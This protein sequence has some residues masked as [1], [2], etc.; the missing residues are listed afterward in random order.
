[1][2]IHTKRPVKIRNKINAYELSKIYIPNKI[3]RNTET[4]KIKQKKDF[5]VNSTLNN[6]GKHSYFNF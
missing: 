2:S 5:Q 1:M 3:N 6:S 4:K